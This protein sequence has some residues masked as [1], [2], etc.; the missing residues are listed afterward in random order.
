MATAREMSEHDWIKSANPGKLLSFLRHLSERKRRLFACACCHA[1]RHLLDDK[2]SW[3]AVLVAERYADGEASAA[4][5]DAAT[6]AANI[7]Y[8]D[9]IDPVHRLAVRA[10]LRCVITAPKDLWQVDLAWADA[11]VAS[12]LGSPDR[13]PDEVSTLFDPWIEDED[14]HLQDT[15][16]IDAP[17]LAALL[18][19]ITGNP[20]NQIAFDP[21]WLTSDVRLLAQGIYADR[22]F[23]RLPI[24]ADALQDAGC[25]NREILAHCRTPDKPHAR[26]C[27]IVD[28]IL[29]KS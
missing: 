5:L 16:Q 22:A 6:E 14:Y 20:F 24:L 10:T 27:W 13:E 2:R 11:A 25:A 26:G 1:I 23:D 17:D 29:G 7:V 19:D 12:E 8:E 21:R 9:T 18:R 15:G 4:E 28:G 3:E